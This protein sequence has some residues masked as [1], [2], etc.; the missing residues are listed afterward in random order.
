MLGGGGC[1]LSDHEIAAVREGAMEERKGM[2][3]KEGQHDAVRKRQREC[4][5]K[6]RRQ[7]ERIRGE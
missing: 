7:K 5:K 4:T 1:F 6:G 3:D 2:K